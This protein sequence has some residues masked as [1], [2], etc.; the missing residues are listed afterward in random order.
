MSRFLPQQQL[1]EKEQ[2][3]SFTDQQTSTGVG[4]ARAYDA[5]EF[6][7]DRFQLVE[8]VFRLEPIPQG[9]L[10]GT[11]RQGTRGEMYRCREQEGI[12]PPRVSSG[13]QIRGID[14]EVMLGETA[15]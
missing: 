15:L 5:I 6:T 9:L 8:K 11:A 13:S 4:R 10:Q 1:L 7:S 12:K 3:L 2:Q 14:K